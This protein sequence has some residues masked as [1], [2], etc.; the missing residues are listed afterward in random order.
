MYSVTNKPEIKK[1][2]TQFVNNS[3]ENVLEFSHKVQII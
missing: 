2:I 1:A 3:N